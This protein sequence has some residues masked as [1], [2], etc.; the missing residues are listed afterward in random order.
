MSEKVKV[1]G[2]LD[3]AGH[4][5]LVL[6]LLLTTVAF[7][8]TFTV[9]PVPQSSLSVV[10]PDQPPAEI[11]GLYV[12]N[13]LMFSQKIFYFHMPVAVV[14]LGILFFTALFGVLFLIKR[15]HRWDLNA[16]VVTE[17]SLLFIIMTM[18]TGEFWTAYE[19]NA[20]WVWEPRLTTYL[21]L[22]LLVIGYFV[23]RSAVED[24]ERRAVFASV[25]G[26]LA[27]ID[28][29]ISLLITRIIPSSRHP[30][31]TR[32]GG[33]EPLMVM[34]LVICIFGMICL[35]FGIYRYRMREQRLR[36][37]LETIKERLED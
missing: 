35:A 27:F 33:L 9:V 24:P 15:D 16:K 32:E 3:L 31:I 22:T 13:A 23:L 11:G 36:I 34:A 17:I 20:W 2:A 28:A 25:F 4:I 12:T 1:G 26:I 14:S 21:I 8:L 19:W 29:V 5:G 10:P 18:V 7:I 30:V 6:G 37:R